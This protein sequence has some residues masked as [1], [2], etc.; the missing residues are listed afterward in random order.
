MTRK[1]STYARKRRHTPGRPDTLAVVNMHNTRLRAGEIERILAPCR[2]ALAALMQGVASYHQWVVLCTAGHVAEAIEDSR[3]IAGQ[4]DII[5]AANDAL[6]AI[7]ERAGR[8]EE[9][10]RPVTCRGSELLALQDLVSAHSR[11]VRELTYGEYTRCADLAVR[12]VASMRGMVFR[13]ELSESAAQAWSA[14]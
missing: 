3:I 14:A 11:Q 8:T 5:Q 7:G 12:R 2:R 9:D 4:R 13:M 1:T 6:D 10:W